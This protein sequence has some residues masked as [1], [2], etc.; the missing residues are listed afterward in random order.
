TSEELEREHG[1]VRKGLLGPAEQTALK[2]SEKNIWTRRYSLWD[3]FQRTE[4]LRK[5]D[6][7]QSAFDEVRPTPAK[8][9]FDFHQDAPGLYLGG[10]DFYVTR[11]GLKIPFY[12]DLKDLYPV[13]DA[14][15][16]SIPPNA[17][18]FQIN[19]AEGV[20]TLRR[21]K[22]HTHDVW[23]FEKDDAPK[24]SK[25]YGWLLR[26]DAPPLLD[27]TCVSVTRAGV[28]GLYLK[29]YDV[30]NDTIS[31]RLEP[32]TI[33]HKPVVLTDNG[34]SVEFFIRMSGAWPVWAFR[35][36]DVSNVGKMF[37]FEL[38]PNSVQELDPDEDVAMS[39]NGL[40]PYFVGD[41]T[42]FGTF[43][44]SLGSVVGTEKKVSA[45][46]VT[47]TFYPR[48]NGP[49]VV[50]A[51]HKRDI[52]LVAVLLGKEVFYGETP[53]LKRG[54]FP[55]THA[56]FALR[57][58][59]DP[60]DMM[61]KIK[62]LLGRAPQRPI[63]VSKKL[64]SKTVPFST[65]RASG[66]SFW[67]VPESFINDIAKF[68]GR[69]LRTNLPGRIKTGEAAI[70]QRG[71]RT[72]FAG[73][74]KSMYEKM[75]AEIGI[76]PMAIAEKT[77]DINGK[78]LTFVT[79]RSGNEIVWVYPKDRVIDMATHFEFT[80]RGSTVAVLSK[81]EVAITPSGLSRV[82]VGDKKDLF[83][84]ARS[85]LPTVRRYEHEMTLGEGENA[86][87][88]F[89]RELNQ[90]ATR[91]NHRRKKVWAF[92]YEDRYKAAAYFDFQSLAP[93]VRQSAPREMAETVPATGAVIKKSEP[94]LP[95]AAPK[96]A[97]TPT[98]MLDDIFENVHDDEVPFTRSPQAKRA[99]L[100]GRV[101]RALRS[102]LGTPNYL[103]EPHTVQHQTDPTIQMDVVPRRY[104]NRNV[105]ATS[106]DQVKHVPALFGV[107]VRSET[108]PTIDSETEMA[109]SG[110]VLVDHFVGTAQKLSNRVRDELGDP[111]ATGGAKTLTEG[112]DSVEFFVRLTGPQ[113][114]WAFKTE[115]LD[116]VGRIFGLHRREGTIDELGDDEV[117]ISQR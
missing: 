28:N 7:L 20:V 12:G 29:D 51:F 102:A 41:P 5:R 104:D 4:R 25:H 36:A 56:M 112:T 3:L 78:P 50:W 9:R 6:A 80:P 38:R 34:V 103:S 47:V 84:R 2:A 21:W 49:W 116:A 87:Q 107:S 75:V 10:Y 117:A 99:G 86:F 64:R 8:Y 79:R 111:P 44:D 33:T 19:T 108:L 22:S 76:A 69:K 62:R 18:S 95:A 59:G 40:D 94:K 15:L 110:S 91:G 37:E 82:F 42:S 71:A 72:Q 89:T 66:Q 1:I 114:V 68:L 17:N 98:V 24:L 88:I 70:S 11:E 93:K 105:W 97:V 43:V 109:A 106:V 54:E 45:K 90:T 61:K 92:R 23:A 73:S 35:R 81:E 85:Q 55:L 57:F 113:I 100:V 26:R 39:R 32:P 46:G 63:D 74:P 52:P 65:R 48:Q 60:S 83:E 96:P 13:M 58:F 115:N 77:L 101:I 16:R 31:G 30:V 53:K 14:L 27:E 67:S